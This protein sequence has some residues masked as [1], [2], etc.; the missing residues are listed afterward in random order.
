MTERGTQL[1]PAFPERTRS[2]SLPSVYYIRRLL[3]QN[4]DHLRSV[5]AKGAA[6]KVDPFCDL[7]ATLESL[8][9][10][11]GTI[12]TTIAELEHLI[13]AHQSLRTHEA[14]YRQELQ[15]IEQKVFWYLG[16]KLYKTDYPA[17]ILIVDDTPL[18]LKLM[19]MTLTQ[20]GYQTYTANSGIE[21]LRIIATTNID[22]VMLD[23]VMPRI[24]GY[25]ICK[26]LKAN[27]KTTPIPIIFM[28]AMQDSA[29]KVKAF[30]SGGADYVTKP[31]QMEE[32][33]A[34]IEYQLKIRSLQQQLEEQSDRLQKEIKER[35][36]A[37]ALCRDFF[38]NA[39]YGM[40]Q[41]TPNGEYSKVNLALAQMY[42]YDSPEALTNSVRNIAQQLY[43]QPQR[44]EEFVE[45]ME[46]H[47]S[48]VDFES[49]VYRQDG[50]VIWIS[51]TVRSVRDVIGDVLFYEGIVRDVTP[52]HSASDR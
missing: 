10:E 7:N 20:Q 44:R 38:E 1:S 11:P 47:G 17:A 40:F 6:A 30:K 35:R 24:D 14:R 9:L 34:R 23:L 46:R 2:L 26:R 50:Q 25:E 16:F 27:P 45:L 52:S 32:V 28:S 31:F 39:I 12:N 36:Q 49:Q 15:N 8:Y 22:L 5:V 4:L 18:N 19:S 33:F 41:T 37:E 29:D 43:V 3:H 13:F 48:I 42:G 51:E 21:A